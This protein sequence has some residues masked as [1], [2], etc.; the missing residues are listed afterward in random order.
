[1]IICPYCDEK[2]DKKSIKCKYC[3][4]IIKKWNK[5]IKIT[6]NKNQFWKTLNIE[7]KNKIKWEFKI[8]LPEKVIIWDV[9]NTDWVIFKIENIIDS[10]IENLNKSNKMMMKSTL[11]VIILFI[12]SFII[13]WVIYFLLKEYEISTLPFWFLFIFI[14][15]M[16]SKKFHR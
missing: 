6:I 8:I 13:F 2:I 10:E 1:M 4:E 16:I 7:W 9:F 5:I 11:L 3:W 12:I 15:Y 14:L